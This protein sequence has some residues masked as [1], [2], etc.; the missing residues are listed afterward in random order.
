MAMTSNEHEQLVTLMT[1]RGVPRAVAEQ[2]ARRAVRSPQHVAGLR[3]A[4]AD[5]DVWVRTVHDPDAPNAC[6]C[7]ACESLRLRQR[8]VTP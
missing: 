2:V 5:R 6:S 7:A 1:E 3:A 8:E 4:M